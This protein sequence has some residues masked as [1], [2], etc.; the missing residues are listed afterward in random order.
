MGSF[1]TGKLHRRIATCLFF[2][3]KKNE[4]RK[5]PTEYLIKSY[6]SHH[7]KFHPRQKDIFVFAPGP[8][9]AS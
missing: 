2:T 7:L 3:S 4:E 5:M 9:K 6:R 8:A 1:C